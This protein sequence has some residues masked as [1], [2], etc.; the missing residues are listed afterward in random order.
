MS[1]REQADDLIRLLDDSA[2]GVPTGGEG[3]SNE[4]REDAKDLEDVRSAI[5]EF[6]RTSKTYKWEDVKAEI[7]S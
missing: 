2:V 4:A 7:A 5:A 3:I 6:R 1:D